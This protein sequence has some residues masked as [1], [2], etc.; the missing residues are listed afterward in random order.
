MSG[1]PDVQPCLVY[2]TYNRVW[3]T[4]RTTVFGLPDVQPCLVYRTYNRVWSTGRTTVSGLPDVQPCLVY[5]TSRWHHCVWSTGRSRAAGIII[6]S[7]IPK[8]GIEL[9]V[10]FTILPRSPN[11][12]I[13]ERFSLVEAQF[14][15][16][17]SILF[18]ASRII[19]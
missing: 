18:T 4:G 16:L 7:L 19:E 2:R 5:R 3:S 15:L 9:F 1:L 10:K 8:N 11:F 12:T 6:T 14:F 17:H 13:K